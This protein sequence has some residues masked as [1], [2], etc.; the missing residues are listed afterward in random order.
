MFLSNHDIYF[1]K[2]YRELIP[3]GAVGISSTIGYGVDELQK[4]IEDLTVEATGRV[5]KCLKVPMNGPH[6]V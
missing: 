4:K 6:L 2:L 5:R 3:E 1:R